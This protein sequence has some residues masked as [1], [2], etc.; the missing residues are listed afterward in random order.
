MM[1]RR[2]AGGLPD[3]RRDGEE[4]EREG[5]DEGGELGEERDRE[6]EDNGGGGGGEQR[7]R[8]HENNGRGGGENGQTEQLENHN[9]LVDGGSDQSSEMP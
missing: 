2:R 7:D 8:E 9:H 1:L 3:I 4:E 6:H 5:V